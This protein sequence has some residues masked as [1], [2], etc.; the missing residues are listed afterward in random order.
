MKAKVS[1]RNAT[2]SKRRQANN[3][4]RPVAPAPQRIIRRASEKLHK[5]SAEV[6]DE[7][8]ASKAQIA[9]EAEDVLREAEAAGSLH[10]IRVL[11]STEEGELLAAIDDYAMRH[12]LNSR[13]QVVR[14]AL[15][16]LLKRNVAVPKWGW[17][18]GRSRKHG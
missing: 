1:K 5:A 9:A 4:R 3:S 16:R 12:G 10:A 15:G 6:R 11:F 8:Q 14:V 18:R 7:V 2:L 13:A 17:P